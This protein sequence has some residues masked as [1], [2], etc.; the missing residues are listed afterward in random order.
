M[1]DWPSVCGRETLLSISPSWVNWPAETS[2]FET[3][4]WRRSGDCHEFRSPVLIRSW[5]WLRPLGFG[6]EVLDG[7]MFSFWRRVGWVDSC[8]G[9]GT[10]PY[11]VRRLNPCADRSV[12]GM[13]LRPNGAV[14]RRDE[15]VSLNGGFDRGPT[16]PPLHLGA[17]LRAVGLSG[18]GCVALSLQ[19][20]SNLLV[21]RA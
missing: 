16:T 2:G 4:F 21:A 7:L 12:L 3:A 1:W 20:L 17:T 5:N 9:L 14:A 13:M 8:F 19:I 6:D 11:V 10:E 15:G 18:P